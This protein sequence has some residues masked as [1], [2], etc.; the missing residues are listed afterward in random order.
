MTELFYSA[1]ELLSPVEGYP[2]INK[3]NEVFARR[4]RAERLVEQHGGAERE[5]E[6]K[7]NDLPQVDIQQLQAS[8]NRYRD[9]HRETQ[10]REFRLTPQI[11]LKRREARTAE[12]EQKKLLDQDKKG[13]QLIAELEVAKDIQDI[14]AN[15]LETMKTRELKKVSDHMNALFL[16]MIGADDSQRSIITRAEIT[17]AFRIVVFGRYDQRLDPSQDLNGASRRALT[18]AFILALTKVS[19]VE[20]PNVIDTPAWDD[21]RICENLD[22]PHCIATKLTTDTFFDP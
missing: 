9:Q 14:L 19:E 6:A 13:Q 5:V 16:E 3:Y 4:Q 17:E 11:E 20:A 8:R 1:Q 21:K 7:I 22:S 2:W 15:A 12:T 18:I 10:N